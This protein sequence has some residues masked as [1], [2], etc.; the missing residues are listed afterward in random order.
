MLALFWVTRWGQSAV[1]CEAYNQVSLR[2][3]IARCLADE[4][5]ALAGRVNRMA[6]IAD[7]GSAN[8]P[9]PGITGV[10]KARLAL[11]A[12]LQE[13]AQTPNTAPGEAGPT[14]Q[15]SSGSIAE[16]TQQP[17]GLQRG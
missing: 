2:L 7:F 5:E 16:E 8:D 10:D 4:N 13:P 1:D 3:A 6:G 17:R 12:F 15:S 9:A 14:E 11:K